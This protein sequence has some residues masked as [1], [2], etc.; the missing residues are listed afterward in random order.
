MRFFEYICINKKSRVNSLNRYAQTAIKAVSL[1]SLGLKPRDA[2]DLAAGEIFDP[3]A[4]LWSAVALEMP[5]WVC[6][7]KDSFGKFLREITPAPA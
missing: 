5:S 1:A 6:A 3:A 4:P 2:W 7:K